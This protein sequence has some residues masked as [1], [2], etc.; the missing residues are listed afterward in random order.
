M[1]IRRAPTATVVGA[2]IVGLSVAW[3]LQDEGFQVTVLD[4]ADARG[5][6]WGNA[7]WLTP[8]LV[9]PL[10]QP[11]VLRYGLRSVLSAASPL[12]LPLMSPLP[13]WSWLA[14]FARNSTPRRSRRA[15]AAL[16]ALSAGALESY[17]DL[18]R[19]EPSLR[20]ADSSL[21]IVLTSER[22]LRHVVHELTAVRD[23]GQAVRFD[24]LTAA[25]AQ[26]IQPGLSG[27]VHAA[28]RLHGQGVIDPTVF[29]P[30]LAQAVQARGARLRPGCRA[31]E[32]A[33]GRDGAVVRGPFGEVSSDHVV[34]ATGAALGELGRRHG[35]RGRIQAGRGYS[36][37]VQPE[38][39]VTE[40]LYL[41]EQR[42]ACTPLAR[43]LRVAGMMELRAHDAPLDVRRV[44]T[45][46]A[47]LRTVLPTARVDARGDEWVGARPCTA[48]G[49]PLIGPTRSAR[50]HVAGGHGMWGV[51]LGP[52]TA[53]LLAR[54][55]ATGQ[56]PDVLRPFDPT[57]R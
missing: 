48:D 13:T 16:S 55:I 46:A 10:P 3:Y 53:R 23:A 27:R 9:A 54:S 7:G 42:I 4:A 44:D 25:E 31:G 51:A 32:V 18:G 1:P 20:F 17:A 14:R 26:A 50:V 29:V 45:L 2:G 11:A 6:S 36:F 56:R 40:P 28:V 38:S 8:A 33:G 30:A 47:T 24:V 21:T 15:Q 43:G 49:L 22:G 57:R 34:L 12:Y 19:S 41:P 39:P 52:V 37:T 5:A 35:V